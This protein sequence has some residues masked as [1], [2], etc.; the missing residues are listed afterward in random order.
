M[1]MYFFAGFFK[2][3]P[4]VW[5]N[6]GVWVLCLSYFTDNSIIKE[7]FWI[8]KHK[9]IWWFGVG[10]LISTINKYHNKCYASYDLLFSC[11]YQPHLHD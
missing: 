11:Y 8:C 10:L 5:P 1:F 7:R 9:S 3:S 4:C 2:I 6:S